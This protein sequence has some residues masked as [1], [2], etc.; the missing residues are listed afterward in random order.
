MWG[1]RGEKRYF[2]SS[3]QWYVIQLPVTSCL[4]HYHHHRLKMYTA[5][6]SLPSLLFFYGSQLFTQTDYKHIWFL[7]WLDSAIINSSLDHNP[8]I[9]LRDKWR[10]VLCNQTAECHRNPNQDGLVL[11]RAYFMFSWKFHFLE[12][13]WRLIRDTACVFV[14]ASSLCFWHSASLV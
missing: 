14:W 2:S 3:R 8:A 1:E 10:Y 5:I 7:M 11:L 6:P 4:Q 12:L 13:V 9:T